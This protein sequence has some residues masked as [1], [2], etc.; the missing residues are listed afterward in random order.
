[1]KNEAA[2][3]D[4]EDLPPFAGTHDVP[5]QKVQ[6]D[7]AWAWL[8]AIQSDGRITAIDLMRLRGLLTAVWEHGRLTGKLEEK[9]QEKR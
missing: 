2:W 6:S 8:A 9:E 1:M 5:E 4:I 3:A 7:H